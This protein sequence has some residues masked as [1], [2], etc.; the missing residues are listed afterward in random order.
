MNISTNISSFEHEYDVSLHMVEMKKMVAMDVVSV[1]L[2]KMK[3]LLLV[4]K[5]GT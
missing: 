4:L 3:P 2:M 1:K 5:H